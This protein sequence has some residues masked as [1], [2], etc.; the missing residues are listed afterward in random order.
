[1][2]QSVLHEIVSNATNIAPSTKNKYLRDLNAWIEYAGDDPRGWTRRAAQGFYASLLDRMK[3]Q[4]ANRLM[5]SIEFASRWWAVQEDN[6]ALDFAKVMK[7]KEG[8]REDKIALTEK[9]ARAL[10]NTCWTPTG[11]GKNGYGATLP[12]DLRDFAMM[13]VGLETGMRRMS[14]RSMAFE[15]TFLDGDAKTGYP[16]ARVLMKGHGNDRVFV[17]LSD[18]A[19]MALR[20]WIN[21][22][23]TATH[24][25]VKLPTTGPIFMALARSTDGHRI[26]HKPSKTAISENAIHKIIVERGKMAGVALSPHVFRHTF[27]TWRLDADWPPHEISAITAHKIGNIGVMG[28]YAKREVIGGKIRNST[29]AWLAELVRKHVEA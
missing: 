29:P 5:A 10:L 19:I 12:I 27:V 14:L 26:G 7:A 8:E 21:W 11:A 20:P 25:G 17:P 1:M 15:H 2:T 3:P 22:L 28:E 23:G 6:P 9:Q 4:S 18:T 24:R 16:T 13:V